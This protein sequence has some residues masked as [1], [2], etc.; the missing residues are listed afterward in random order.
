MSSRSVAL[1][2]KSFRHPW[3]PA[4]RASIT[5]SRAALTSGC[6]TLWFGPGPR[7]ITASPRRFLSQ[8]TIRASLH[9]DTIRNTTPTL[10]AGWWPDPQIAQG[11]SLER[12]P[13]SG[14]RAVLNQPLTVP[15]LAPRCERCPHSSSGGDMLGPLGVRIV[16]AEELCSC[17]ACR[18]PLPPGGSTCAQGTHEPRSRHRWCSGEEH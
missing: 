11:P 5:K 3:E 18:G 4:R 14:H 8:A 15:V 1:G 9:N 2:P 12:S 16:S 7:T 10:R 17:G 13:L 6:S